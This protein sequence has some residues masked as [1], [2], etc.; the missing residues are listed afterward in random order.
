M[1]SLGLLPLATKEPKSQMI[2]G[3]ILLLF[4]I[5]WD[6]QLL[7]KETVLFCKWKQKLFAAF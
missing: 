5:L 1:S 6:S 2:H 4:F 3:N 7:Q